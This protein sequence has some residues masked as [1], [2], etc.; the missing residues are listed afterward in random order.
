MMKDL[1][2]LINHLQKASVCK[3]SKW[4]EKVIAMGNLDKSR[5][6]VLHLKN[7][8]EYFWSTVCSFALLAMIDVNTCQMPGMG[9]F[10]LERLVKP[11]L[12]FLKFWRVRI[13]LKL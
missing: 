3:Y 4:L 1:G 12:Y 2:F 6:V 8:W 7:C 5:E 9:S 10:Y 13:S 11:G